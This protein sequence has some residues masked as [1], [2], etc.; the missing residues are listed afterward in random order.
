MDSSIP[1]HNHTILCICNNFV[2]RQRAPI[3]SLGNV[4]I[5]RAMSALL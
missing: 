3:G 2:E 5:D 1:I 4:A